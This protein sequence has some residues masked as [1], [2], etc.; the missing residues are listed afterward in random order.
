MNDYLWLLLGFAILIVGGDMLVRNAVKVA[1]YLRVPYTVIG[2]VLLGF[3]TSAPELVTSIQAAKAGS[4][5]IAVGNFVGSNITNV[6]LVL[7]FAATIAPF[8]LL[9]LDTKRDG[10][11]M[12]AS[13]VLFTVM[14][15]IW[16]LDQLAG[17]ILLAMLVGY[18]TMTIRSAQT[19]R[20]VLGEEN[21]LALNAQ[22][23]PAQQKKVGYV[24]PAVTTSFGTSALAFMLTLVGLLGIIVGSDFLVHAA[25]DIAND[26]GVSQSVIGVSVVA[27]GTSLPELVAVTF[28][29]LKGRGDMA[30]GGIIGSNIYNTLMIGGVTGLIAPNFV[31]ADI[32]SYDVFVMVAASTALL[33]IACT[34]QRLRRYEGLG[35]LSAYGIYIYSIWP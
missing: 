21:L 3:G 17:A 31:P 30:L 23:T 26:L 18:I 14:A 25:I 7:G 1:E 10:Y 28:A 9:D 33:I 27:L 13:A 16:P 11:I 20:E 2:V 32:A 4:P 24:E 15:Q 12:F 6:L 34:G 22:V 29:A 5:G 19:S 35:L 8:K